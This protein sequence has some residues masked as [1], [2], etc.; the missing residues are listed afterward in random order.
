VKPNVDR[1]ASTLRRAICKNLQAVPNTRPRSAWDG[2]DDG[3]ADP[4]FP[5]SAAI[6]VDWHRPVTPEAAGSS[7]VDPAN[8]LSQ[9]KALPLL[10]RH[11]L[12]KVAGGRG[13]GNLQDGETPGQTGLD[14]R[15]TV[16]PRIAENTGLF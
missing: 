7:P 9:S 14:F 10:P 6:C 5:G 15:H 3:T 4:D 1:I 16:V 8:Y 12:A 2:Q 11:R 13:L